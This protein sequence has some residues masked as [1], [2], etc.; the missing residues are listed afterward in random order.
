MLLHP[1]RRL[2]RSSSRP[3]ST[4]LCPPHSAADLSLPTLLLGSPWDSGSL[5]DFTRTVFRLLPAPRASSSLGAAHVS[6]ALTPARGLSCRVFVSCDCRKARQNIICLEAGLRGYR[7]RGR[8]PVK[9]SMRAGWLVFS[10]PTPQEQ[11]PIS[12]GLLK[13]WISLSCVP[14]RRR[15]LFRTFQH[16]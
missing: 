6:L 3:D 14:L 11:D 1:Q 9:G 13:P 2:G 7:P 4:A 5:A 15:R 16:R 12:L 10:S 8:Q